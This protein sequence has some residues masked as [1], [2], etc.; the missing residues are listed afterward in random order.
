MSESSVNTRNTTKKKNDSTSQADTPPAVV[1][2][3]EIEAIVNI[4][5]AAAIAGVKTEFQK[6][7]DDMGTKLQSMEERMEERIARLELSD[8]GNRLQLIEERMEERITRTELTDFDN[9]FHVLEERMEERFGHLESLRPGNDVDLRD[10]TADVCSI[11]E[12]AR[13]FAIA[14]NNNEQYQRRVNLRFKGISVKQDEDC[15]E[16]IIDFVRK[17]MK[18]PISEKDVDIAHI[19]PVQSSYAEA[20]PSSPT[21]HRSTNNRSEPR[22][23]KPVPQIIARFSNKEVRDKII[24]NRSVLKN[25]NFAIVE[26]LTN[27]N[28]KT[29]NRVKKHPAVQKVWSWNGRVYATV[30]G[31]RKICVKPFEPVD[32]LLTS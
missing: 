9:K 31:G 24:R 32:N 20:A 30:T 4:A 15:R 25:M 11:R 12:E 1:G 5:V 16:V 22:Q 8:I 6:M 2:Q 21:S 17:T 19:L 7:F 26:D 23:K 10:I 29:M 28:A 27:L 18:M 13:A 3:P 14:A